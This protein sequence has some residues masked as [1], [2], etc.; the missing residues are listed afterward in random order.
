VVLSYNLA[1]D[2]LKK[3]PFSAASISLTGRNL[4]LFTNVPFMDPDGYANTELAEPTYRNIGVNI[5]LK[6]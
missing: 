3:T 1:P 6:F 2:V 4:L 5:N